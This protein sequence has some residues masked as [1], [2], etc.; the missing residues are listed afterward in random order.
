MELRPIKILRSRAHTILDVNRAE[1][2]IPAQYEAGKFHCWENYSTSESSQVYAVVEY[3]DG[4][5][6]RA[7]PDDIQFT[8]V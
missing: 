7:E 5:V 8:D 1:T 3:S 6:H 4:S 2:K